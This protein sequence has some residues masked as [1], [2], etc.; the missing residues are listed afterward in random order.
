[1]KLEE[2]LNK[3]IELWWKPKWLNYKHIEQHLWS[4]FMYPDVWPYSINDLC[5]I[6]S[7]LR[8]FVCEKRLHDIRLHWH[9][10]VHYPCKLLSGS[11]LGHDTFDYTYRIM[12]SSIQENK[13]QFILDNII[14][15]S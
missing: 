7:W 15:P 6:E 13:E 2:L 14:L 9:I 3:L 5:S 1:M 8:Q 4:Y 11:W 10:L 12:L